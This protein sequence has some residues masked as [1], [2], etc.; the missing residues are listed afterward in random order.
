PTLTVFGDAPAIVTQL[1]PAESVS[2]GS[3]SSAILPLNQSRAS[4][5]KG[6]QARRCAPSGVE[7]LDASSRRSAMTRS[8]FIVRSR[9]QRG[10]AEAAPHDVCPTTSAGAAPLKRCPTTSDSS[11]V[12]Q[13]RCLTPRT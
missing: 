4:R 13:L 7:V 5:H 1:L 11:Y 8:A 2:I 9:I 6:P 10:T 3:P 12:G